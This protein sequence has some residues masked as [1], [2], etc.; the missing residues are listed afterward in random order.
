MHG[1]NPASC[2]LGACNQHPLLFV[3]PAPFDQDTRPRRKNGWP[4]RVLQTS[5]TVTGDEICGPV[6][7]TG[8][9][10]LSAQPSVYEGYTRLYGCF[11]SCGKMQI[12]YWSVKAKFSIDRCPGSP[13][14]QYKW[15]IHPS[16][17]SRITLSHSSAK[18]PVKHISALAKSHVT[19]LNQTPALSTHDRIPS[20]SHFR[21]AVLHR[22]RNVLTTHLVNP[23]HLHLKISKPMPW[24]GHRL[25]SR[26]S[27]PYNQNKT[28]S[29]P[30]RFKY[31][32][33]LF[34]GVYHQHRSA[35]H[36]DFAIHRINPHSTKHRLINNKTSSIA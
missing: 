22:L 4:E 14:E 15:T 21:L 33:H 36:I 30:R 28:P 10:W 3:E 34:M 25:R 32:H 27:V 12:L 5:W 26:H 8:Y 19:K 20:C 29:T 11:C 18:K 16:S 23:P 7:F 6:H 1:R 13:T 9:Y 35:K 24:T 17:S 2:K 31:S